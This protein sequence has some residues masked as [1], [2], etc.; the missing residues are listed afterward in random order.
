MLK[1]YTSTTFINK[2]QMEQMVEMN[3]LFLSKNGNKPRVSIG[4]TVITIDYYSLCELYGL[5][6]Q[7][8]F[9]Q[10]DTCID[11]VYKVYD[12][13][14]MEYNGSYVS[15]AILQ[16]GICDMFT[17]FRSPE[18]S[19]I[20]EGLTLETFKQLFKK[21]FEALTCIHT[22]DFVHLDIKP[23][24]VVVII[25]DD[26]SITPMLIDFGFASPIGSDICKKRTM[27]TETFR[28]EN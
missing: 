18:F 21:I 12:F 14:I 22:K 20:T 5:I 23:E 15:Y 26:G 16:A 10:S 3:N 25:G 1:Y 9:S 4:G 7:H 17:L 6:I 27:G 13:G 28:P 11:Y 8:F 2:Q 19:G 24:N